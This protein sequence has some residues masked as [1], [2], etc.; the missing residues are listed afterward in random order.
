MNMLK[1]MPD[2]S[3]F[4]D[5]SVLDKS[6]E[7]KFDEEA[8]SAD[9]RALSLINNWES[10]QYL[11]PCQ[12]KAQLQCELIK[13]FTVH[14]EARAIIEELVECLHH[15]TDE[16]YGNSYTRYIKKAQAFLKE[17]ER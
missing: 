4:L 12:K 1:D 14:D 5:G 6:D 11:H 13:L 7:K 15:E 3:K 10:K 16:S 8:V 9:E 2:G 17:T